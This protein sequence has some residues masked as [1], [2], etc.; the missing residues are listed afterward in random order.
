[1]DAKELISQFAIGIS[2]GAIGG[3]IGIIATTLSED[4]S[5]GLTYIFSLCLLAYFVLGML[6]VALVD[7]PKNQ[8]RWYSLLLFISWIF[9]MVFLTYFAIIFY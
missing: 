5:H 6:Y 8:S 9:A 4:N 7:K 2:T 1:M 3:L